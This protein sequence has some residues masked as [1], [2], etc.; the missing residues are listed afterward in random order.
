MKIVF[1][2]VKQMMYHHHV[3]IQHKDK[4]DKLVAIASQER[5]WRME[6]ILE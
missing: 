6:N 4:E 3:F 5:E 2:A 1:H